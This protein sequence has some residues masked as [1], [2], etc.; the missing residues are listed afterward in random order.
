MKKLRQ[1]RHI[2]MSLLMELE[3]LLECFS[4]K[5]PPLPGLDFFDSDF[6]EYAAFLRL[7]W[8]PCVLRAK[9]NRLCNFRGWATLPSCGN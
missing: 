4:T 5:I 3:N 1:E 7:P 9:Q 2:L 8:L 6:C